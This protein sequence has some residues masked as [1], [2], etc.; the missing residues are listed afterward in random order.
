VADSTHE[1]ILD[2]ADARLKAL[3]LDGMEVHRR[4][5]LADVALGANIAYPACVYGPD[6]N[7]VPLSADTAGEERFYPLTVRLLA[8]LPVEDPAV[9][10]R[11]LR[12]RR[13]VR[14]EFQRK[15]FAAG[16]VDGY[17]AFLQPSPVVETEA[18]SVGLL[19][20]RLT[21]QVGVYESRP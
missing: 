1:A 5:G 15:P 14:D 19:S 10:P 2:E 7:E 4:A 21:F 16:G 18:E 12:W 20:T 9:L 13:I 8:R 11:L 3:P 6:G 17:A